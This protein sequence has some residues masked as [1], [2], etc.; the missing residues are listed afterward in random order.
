V[1]EQT[2][3]TP[4][5]LLLDIDRRNRERL[6]ATAAA[7]T[8]AAGSQSAGWLAV[9]V[10]PWNFLLA[11]DDVAEIIPVPRVTIVPGVKPWLLGI[12]NLR[13]TVMVVV[14]LQHYLSG[15]PA[16]QMPNSR[17]IVVRSGEWHY[18][19]LAD[20]IIDRRQFSADSRLPNLN[21]IAANLRPYL[22]EAFAAGQQHWLALIIN[23]LLDDPR[24]LN[25]TG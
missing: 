10:G 8:T 13:G 4:F 16:V 12:A 18:G 20:E 15:K 14:D 7:T 11:M 23:R 17:L 19:L 5:D 9:R 22:S 6:P 21:S 25:A 3:L 24:F 2:A 1:A